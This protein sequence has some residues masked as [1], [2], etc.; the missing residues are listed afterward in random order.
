M[1]DLMGFV[2]APGP[3][4]EGALSS[5]LGWALVGEKDDSFQTSKVLK[6]E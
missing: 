3:G 2:A 6:S 5:A 4:G 1:S